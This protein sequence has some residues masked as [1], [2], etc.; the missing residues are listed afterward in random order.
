MLF[1]HVANSCINEVRNVYISTGYFPFIHIHAGHP[2]SL[3]LIAKR[4]L[5]VW[6]CLMLLIHSPGNLD[7]GLPIILH[8]WG[9]QCHNAK[10]PKE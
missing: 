5:L 6:L 4:Q 9:K 8:L 1:L 10:F 7:L 3:S 2:G